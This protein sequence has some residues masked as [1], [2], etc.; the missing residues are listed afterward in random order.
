MIIHDKTL[1]SE[2]ILEEKF[3]CDLK[4]CKGACCVEGEGGAPLTKE[5]AHTIEENWD[6]IKKHL[7]PEAIATV[8]KNGFS[9]QGFDG[10]LE[11]PLMEGGEECVYTIFE[12]DGTAKCGI[13]KSYRNGEIDFMKP[14]SCHLYPIR[15]HQL[16]TFEA[17]NYHRWG[18]CK[19]ACSLGC[20]LKVPI[21]KFL[22]APLIR[23]YGEAWYE[24]LEKIAEAYLENKKL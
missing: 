5:E 2:E 14:L 23:K 18:I 21:Y 19:D 24:G 12:E 15:T 7:K 16:P 8:E 10:G 20:E 11:T 3:V 6:K 17:L 22:K 13:E 9:T 4:A 1:I